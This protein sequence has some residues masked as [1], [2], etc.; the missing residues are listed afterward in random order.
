MPSLGDLPSR[1]H[2]THLE[3]G[4]SVKRQQLQAQVET[5]GA[6]KKR[7]TWLIFCGMKDTVILYDSFL[8]YFHPTILEVVPLCS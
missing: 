7:Q 2:S 6:E 5:T 3:K 8:S 4:T 1:G